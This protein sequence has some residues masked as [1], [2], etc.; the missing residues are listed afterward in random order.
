M[1]NESVATNFESASDRRRF[2]KTVAATTSAFFSLGPSVEA[3]ARRSQ[4]L[5][6]GAQTNIWGVPIK[7]YSHL[8]QDIEILARLGYQGFET[9]LTSVSP[10]S[11][12]ASVCR[13]DFESRHIQFVS[14]HASGVLYD[15]DKVASELEGLE[16]AA[17]YTAQMGASHLIVSAPDVPHPDGKLDLQAVHTKTK[18]LNRL[19]AAV[20]KDGL[21]LCYHNHQPEFRDKPSQMSYLLKETDPGLVS[22]CLDVGHCYGLID[23]AAFTAEHYRRI[24]I[25]HLRDE[26]RA[27]TGEVVDTEPGYGKINLKGIVAPLLN[28]D[29]EGWLELEE[30]P[31]YPK[32]VKDPELILRTWREYL[33]ELTHV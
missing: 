1:K 6:I 16:R 2:L 25:F 7:D 5:R 29:W 17:E 3:R 31:F 8:L 9:S 21:K 32:A 28:S 22:L 12:R 10:Q 30:S 26:T 15:Q 14:A 11:G 4:R 24:A 33:R 27:V 19:G 18:A 13:R 20:K 23:P